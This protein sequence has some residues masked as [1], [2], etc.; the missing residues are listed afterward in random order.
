MTDVVEIAKERQARLAAE[1]AKLDEFL[2]MAEMLVKYTP[3]EIEQGVGHCGRKG[4]WRKW[5][6]SRARGLVRLQTDSQGAD[7]EIAHQPQ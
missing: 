4:R 2:R 3:F 5:R 1:I 6:R 7:A